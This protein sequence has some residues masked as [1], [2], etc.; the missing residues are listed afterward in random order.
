MTSIAMTPLGRRA[1]GSPRETALG[2]DAS[3]LD[4]AQ[5][6][7]AV[8][9]AAGAMQAHAPGP[10]ERWAVLGDNAGP[11]LLAHAA[12]LLAGVGTVAV[13]RQLT[14]TEL[15]Y[16]FKDAGVVAVIT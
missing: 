14:V 2:D 4:W 9:G 16:Q 10:G 7:S 3:L 8:A 13:S 11:T 6:V 1:G 12:G 5:V 15:T